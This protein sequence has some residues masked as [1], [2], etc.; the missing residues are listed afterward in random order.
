MDELEGLSTA[1]EIASIEDR[2]R[3]L[4]G[5]AAMIPRFTSGSNTGTRRLQA[6]GEFPPPSRRLT[7]PAPPRRPVCP[8]GAMTSFILRRGSIQPRSA[9]M[10][11]PTLRF[12][13]DPNKKPPPPHDAPGRKDPRSA[14]LPQ[15]TV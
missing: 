11:R 3:F 5:V 9:T 14:I 7:G 4:D 1:L 12:P 15:T 2:N 10:L 13:S 6:T 8:P